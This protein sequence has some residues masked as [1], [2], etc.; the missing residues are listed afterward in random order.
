MINDK[1]ER[2]SCPG[3]RFQFLLLFSDRLKV[4]ALPVRFRRRIPYRIQAL[5]LQRLRV[6]MVVQL[7]PR[8]PDSS[9]L[10]DHWARTG[11]AYSSR[12]HKKSM[13]ERRVIYSNSMTANT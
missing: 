7:A 4:R 10:P 6:C 1:M 13:R 5:V 12:P 8:P 9:R 3:R 11:P 2:L